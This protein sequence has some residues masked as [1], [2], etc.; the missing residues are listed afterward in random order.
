KNNIIK[1]S[2]SDKTEKLEKA[3][4]ELDDEYDRL[5][6]ETWAMTFRWIL[7]LE[8]RIN[9]EPITTKEEREEISSKL[10]EK[11]IEITKEGL[12][13]FALGDDFVAKVFISY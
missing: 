11:Y 4:T 3:K 1:Y 2:N 8:K 10:P 13:T 7:V 5:K 12:N 9:D 6:N